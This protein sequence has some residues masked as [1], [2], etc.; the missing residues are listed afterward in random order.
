M[1]DVDRRRSAASPSA[2]PRSTAQEQVLDRRQNEARGPHVARD[3]HPPSEAVA[4]AVI[5][6]TE[7]AR[8]E[9]TL[10]D[11]CDACFR[12]HAV[13]REALERLMGASKA[14]LEPFG[15]PYA[16]PAMAKAREALEYR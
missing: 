4:A 10:A 3:P 8:S 15:R 9:R 5:E 13:L 12:Q 6:A 1:P 2:D 14:Y 7:R 16:H 11:D